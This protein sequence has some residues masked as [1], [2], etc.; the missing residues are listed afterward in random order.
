MKSM[1]WVSQL[2]FQQAL[3]EILLQLPGIQ[4]LTVYPESPVKAQKP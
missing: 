1:A 4:A 3:S 2:E